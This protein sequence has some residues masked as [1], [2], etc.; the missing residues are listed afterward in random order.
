MASTLRSSFKKSS[1]SRMVLG[2][3]VLKN[4]ELVVTR[5]PFA[6]AALMADT[7]SSKTP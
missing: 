1:T 7:A 6:F 2:E 4:V 3:S 5:K